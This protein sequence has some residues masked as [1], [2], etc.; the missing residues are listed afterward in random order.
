[1]QL[2]ISAVNNKFAF[3]HSFLTKRSDDELNT[4]HRAESPRTTE[5]RLIPQHNIKYYKRC[6]QEKEKRISAP[7]FSERKKTET[8]NDS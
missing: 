8:R 1:M 5:K 3:F 6:H 4:G 2:L 7:L